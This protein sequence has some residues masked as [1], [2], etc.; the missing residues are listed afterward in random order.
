MEECGDISVIDLV[1]CCRKTGESRHVRRDSGSVA[2]D[3]PGDTR[4]LRDE[5]LVDKECPHE[6][7]TDDHCGQGVRRRPRV[8]NTTPCKA[9]ERKGR[10]G[11]DDHVS[12]EDDMVRTTW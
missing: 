5:P 6:D 12:T 3:F 8:R 11:N 10:T 4:V 9:N 2:H 7:Q 1:L